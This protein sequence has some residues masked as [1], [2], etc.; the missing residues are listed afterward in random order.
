MSRINDLLS[1]HD[2]DRKTRQRLAMDEQERAENGQFGSGSGGSSKKAKKQK[3]KEGG[4]SITGNE[5]E[6]HG[7]TAKVKGNTVSYTHAG[8]GDWVGQTSTGSWTAPGGKSGP[9]KASMLT[10]MAER[11]EQAKKENAAHKAMND[12]YGAGSLGWNPF[13][14]LAKNG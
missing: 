14:G 2:F 1:V 5:H 8:S 3:S 6:A 10:Y 4:A 13:A 7:Y 9:D 12:K 11:N